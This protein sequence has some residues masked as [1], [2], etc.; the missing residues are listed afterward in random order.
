MYSGSPLS[1]LAYER[2]VKI[3][4][5]KCIAYRQRF[6]F[7][8]CQ[9]HFLTSELVEVKTEVT[10]VMKRNTALLNLVFESFPYNELKKKNQACDMFKFYGF[11]FYGNLNG[12]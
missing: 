8:F 1:A 11:L 10:E 5:E 3:S 9:V 12:T 4:L 6:F 2:P 7:F